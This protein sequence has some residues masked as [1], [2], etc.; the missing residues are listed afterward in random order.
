MPIP[1]R[2]ANPFCPDC[3][4]V[5]LRRGLFIN[6]GGPIGCIKHTIGSIDERKDDKDNKDN[7]GKQKK[8]KKK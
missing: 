8:E 4:K 7:K 1:S 2:P 6:D 5:F 3:W